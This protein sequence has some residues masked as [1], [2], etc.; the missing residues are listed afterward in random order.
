LRNNISLSGSVSIAN[1]DAKFNSWDTA[2]AA[3][4][5]D[6]LSVDLS[7]ATAT[8][9]ADGSLSNNNL[10][11]LT[12]NSVLINAGTNIGLPYLGSAPDLGAFEKK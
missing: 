9:N 11:K 10:F 1:A 3:I 6:F 2:P 8:R 4:V 12:A 7:L 5:A